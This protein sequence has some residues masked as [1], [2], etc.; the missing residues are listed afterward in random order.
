MHW[1]K[2]AG[3]ATAFS[4]AV[5]PSAFA[6]DTFVDQSTGSDGNNCLSAASPCATVQ[7]GI[8]K[9]TGVN[10]TI[11]VAP[12][13]YP[14]PAPNPIVISGNRSLEATGSPA[15][16]TLGTL[17]ANTTGVVQGFTFEGD[18]SLDSTASV[19][20]Q[21]AATVKGNIFKTSPSGTPVG[22]DLRIEFGSGSPTVTGNTFSDDGAGDSAAVVANTL[23]SP[24]ISDNHISG[25]HIGIEVERGT[26]TLSRND[27]SSIYN[28]NSTGLGAAITV[29]S[30]EGATSPTITANLI[31]D[32]TN[33]GGINPLPDGVLIIGDS[34]V[35]TP[36]TGATL[37]RNQI[38]G[39][40]TA[41][42]VGG[43]DGAVTLDGDLL[44]G[45]PEGL[46]AFS[47]NAG[48]SFGD[49]TATNITVDATTRDI[50]LQHTQLTLNSSI[51][52]HAIV[53]VG[54]P[55]ASDT[56]AITFSRGPT[57]TPGGNGCQ[58]F[59]TSAVP[60]YA[61]SGD[62]HLMA[63]NPALID[64]G[65]GAVV[66]GDLFDFDG[67]AR[68]LAGTCG[69]TTKPDI[70]ADEFAPACSSVNTSI[71]SGPADGSV[72]SPSP[73]FGFSLTPSGTGFQCSLDGASYSACTSPTTYAGLGGGA[74]TFAVRAL[75][76]DGADPSPATRSWVV[77]ASPPDTSF[78]SG[79]PAGG[80]S[81]PTPGFTFSSTEPSSTFECSLDGGAFASC[82]VSHLS[83]GSHTL[84]ARAIDP[85]GN[86]DPTPAVRTWTVDATPPET[87]ID[88]GP[89]EGS[90]ANQRTA[91]FGFSSEAGASFECSLD[92][93]RVR[94]LHEP[95]RLLGS[96]RRPAFVQGPCDR[97][98]G[99]RRPVARH[100]KLDDRRHGAGHPD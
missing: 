100:E 4:L 50:V 59:Q 68:A 46:S 31:H 10:D 33:V 76:S 32:P 77:D 18:S 7:G 43:T 80:K 89:A 91:S 9:A 6:A 61:A 12:G 52:G 88:A 64:Q 83:D 5:A 57:T 23:G 69:G 24:P 19:R 79:P 95:Q 56:C 66:H 81:G 34:V 44:V 11:R 48:D 94:G 70:G 51:V 96:S 30:A 90:V 58:N 15:S 36:S 49:V 54:T 35:G 21:A 27:I 71:D 14:A 13:I 22:E 25:Y 8:D 93:A 97:R 28:S 42:K 78:A 3:L 62:Y 63:S 55:T 17:Y 53:S 67:D 37:R 39:Y 40:S 65:D 47:N 86:V 92:G 98:R 38:L 75:D 1:A 85:A 2:V 41:V 99:Q 84:L 60:N 20:I 16:T 74:H 87:Q 72:S 26:P 73:S 82:N 29:S 45:A